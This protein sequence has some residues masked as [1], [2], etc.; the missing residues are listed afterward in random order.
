M[1]VLRVRQTAEGEDAYRVLL[2]L[3]ANGQRRE[4]TR[5]FKFKLEAQDQED[6]RWYL[7]DY[8]VYPSDAERA[9]AKRIEARMDEI[10]A[11]LFGAVLAGTSVWGEARHDLAETRV[12]VVTGVQ[13]ATAIPWELLR[14]PDSGVPLAL[15]ARAFVRGIHNAAQRPK[16]PTAAGGPV[17]VLLAICRP[18]GGDDVPFRSVERRLV[19]GLRGNDAAQLT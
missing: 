16:L 14:D 1:H 5:Q 3:E 10:G 11:E 13:E 9:I 12:E 19:E 4:D 2:E 8:L 17:R 18:R 15:R 7:E 6:L